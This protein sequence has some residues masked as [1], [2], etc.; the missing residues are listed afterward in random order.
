M[1]GRVRRIDAAAAGGVEED[2]LEL[3]RRA[4]P[5]GGR[6]RACRAACSRRRSSA[7]AVRLPA[8]RWTLRIASAG[9]RT[10]AGVPCPLADRPRA[11]ASARSTRPGAV[12]A[13]AS[14]ARAG[15]AGAACAPPAPASARGRPVVAGGEP[16][17]ARLRRAQQPRGLLVAGRLGDLQRRTP[18]RA[19][20]DP[21]IRARVGEQRPHDAGVAAE[22]RPRERGLPVAVDGVDH[23]RRIR[24]QPL[25][26]RQRHRRTPRRSAASGP[27]RPSRSDRC[28]DGRAAAPRR[29]HL[30]ARRRRAARSARAPR[31]ALTSIA[32]LASS[33]AATAWKPSAI[34]T[35]RTVQR[36]SSLRALT[37]PPRAISSRTAAR[38]PAS[39]A[40][41]NGVIVRS[42]QIAPPRRN[43]RSGRRSC[44]VVWQSSARGG[45]RRDDQ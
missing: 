30:R 14:A 33:S 5:G 19:V 43:G 7:C 27:G 9:E 18:V 38:S 41:Y 40:R 21:G 29:A 6:G 23:G 42:S 22:R 45:L 34:A 3:G 37:S 39:T 16:V 28:P 15:R 10:A 25:H 2:P 36:L 1:R 17:L 13:P 35:M 4:G 12:I 8:L 11:A 20:R 26:E 31:E 24:E 32:G 44:R